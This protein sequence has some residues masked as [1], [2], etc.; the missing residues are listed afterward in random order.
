MELIQKHGSEIFEE[1]KAAYYAARPGEER[2]ALEHWKENGCKLLPPAGE[3]GGWYAAT[4]EAY[5]RVIDAARNG[6]RKTFCVLWT[7]GG[8]TTIVADTEEEAREKFYALPAEE[9]G[10]IDDPDI[11]RIDEEG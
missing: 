1:Y 2:G 10:E 3:S 7:F 11:F 8:S 5:A 4:P 9:F 6:A